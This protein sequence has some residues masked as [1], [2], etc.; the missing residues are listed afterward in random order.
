MGRALYIGALCVALTLVAGCHKA[1]ETLRIGTNVWPGYEPLYLARD[2][3]Y[4]DD[5]AVHL[6]EYTSATQV[7][8]AYR[9]GGIDAAAL[10]LD[11]MI[12][13]AT[14]GTPP[15]LVLVMD[16]SDGADAVLGRANVRTLADLAG[17]RIGVENTA[18]GGY[19]LSRTLEHGK[20]SRSDIEVVTLTV[21]EHERAFLNGDVDAV[22][23]FEP[24]SS[25]LKNAGAVLLFDSSGI[26]GEVV[27]VLVVRPEFRKAHRD[28]VGEVLDAWFQ[29]VDFLE[30]R[31]DEAAR[32][33]KRRLRLS[34]ADILTAF[35][36]LR[37]PDCDENR[38]L[39]LG[40]PAP[41][42][43]TM[44]H[45]M[46]VMSGNRQI[47]APVPTEGIVKASFVSEPGY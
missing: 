19:M 25:R 29:A 41:I 47:A 24:V 36:T 15:E 28:T 34:E 1:E 40:T 21:D 12:Q 23:T 33:M 45:L 5:T 43:S 42:E 46:K 2:L 20:L 31:P 16:V 4:F 32:Y 18:L 26:P 44:Q 11:E 38:A 22:V 13:L 37:I 35:E 3:G 6:V 39:L 7:L 9:N 27:D 10:T 14:H 8:A 30:T 17:R